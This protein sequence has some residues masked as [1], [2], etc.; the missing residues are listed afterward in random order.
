MPESPTPNQKPRRKRRWLRRMLW[1][2]LIFLGLLV[3]LH[4]PLV[5]Y[6]GRWVAIRIARG[7]NIELDLRIEG[8]V[9]SRLE[10]HDVKATKAGTGAAPIERLSLDRLVVEYSIPQLIRGD[11]NGL[12]SAEIGTLE[13]VITPLPDQKEPPPKPADPPAEVLRKLLAKPLPAPR[14][15]I[16][17]VDVRVKQV[18]GDLAVRNF[19]LHLTPGMPGTMGWDEI[20]LPGT[21]PLEAFRGTTQ[22]GPGDLR[23]LDVLDDATPA[24]A[25]AAK[26][27]TPGSIT[28][29]LN[30]L[31]FHL[32]AAVAP[33]ASGRAIKASVRLENL[34]VP[35]VAEKLGHELPLDAS[36]SKVAV[37]FAG[38]PEKPATWAATAEIAAASPGMRMIN[39]ARLSLRAALRE[40]LLHVENLDVSASGVRFHADGSLPVPPSIF[41][42][43]AKLP[44]VSGK[45]AFS[46]EAPDLAVLGEELKVPLAGG[47]KTTGTA[48]AEQGRLTLDVAMEARAVAAQGA[49]V[50]ET[51]LKLRATQA[52]EAMEDLRTLVAEAELT[53]HGIESAGVQI[54]TAR[55]TADLRELQ[56]R[57]RSLHVERGEST[58]DATATAK[59]T[60]KGA[61]AGSPEAQVSLLVP[62]LGDFQI[63]VNGAPLTGSASGEI[64]VA[65]GTPVEKS[66]GTFQL[67]AANL[68]LGDEAVGEMLVEGQIADGQV[69][70]KNISAQLAGQTTLAV[71][72]RFGIAA[73]HVYQA[74]VKL[75]APDLSA[76][77]PILAKL[78]Q[79]KPIA[80]KVAL[81]FEG[82]GDLAAPKG[83]VRLDA[84][85]VRYDTTKV[86]DAR[87]AANVTMDS[88]EVTEFLVVMD[89]LRAQAR[90]DWKERKVT[91]SNV[92]VQLDGN[93]VLSGSLNVP[94]DPWAPQP[95]PVNQPIQIDF[96]ARELDVARLLASLGQP[97]TAAGTVSATLKAG[98]TL[99]QPSLKLEAR[100]IKLRALPPPPDPKRST[101]K[102]PQPMGT[103]TA[104]N[105]V[106]PT[107]FET[108]VALEGSQLQVSGVIRQP[109]IQP[110]TFSANSTIDVKSLLEGK[111]LDW[112]A[113]PLKAS[114]DLPASSL[115]FLPRHVPAIARIDGTAAVAVRAGGTLG[116]P[117]LD[118]FTT[119]DV[120]LARMTAGSVPVITNFKS[121]LNFSG[122]RVSIGE[123]AGEAGGGRFTLSGSVGVA[124]FAEPVFDLALQSKD[125]L[126]LRDDSVLIRA[127]TDLALRGPLNAATATGTV[128]ITQSRFN[129]EI[130]ILPLQLPG[131]PKP[132]PK[133]AAQPTRIS[134]PKPPLRDWKFDIAVQ[135]RPD[136]PFLVRGNLAKGQAR[137][138]VKLAG[139]GLFPYLTGNATVEQFTA[140]LPLSTMTTRRGLVTFSQ[141]APFQPFLDLE[142]QSRIR[143]Y[144]IVAYINGPA[145]KPKLILESEPPLPQTEILSLLTTGSLTGEVGANNTALATR[146]A[147]LVVKSWYKKLFK[148]D[149][150]LTAEDTGGESI[151]D[152]FEV[153]VGAV[154]AKTGRSEITAQVRVTD[155]LF[156]I[157]DLEMGG[158]ISGRVKY[159]FRFR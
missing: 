63:A 100:G 95:L 124:N 107:D 55:L 108:T 48:T 59:L 20:E 144:T 22:F 75:D 92:E 74:K 38:D 153:D 69:L 80:G 126:V 88:A 89:K 37:T 147:V 125:V 156:F 29:T 14:V 110:L 82:A 6:G 109:L 31:G 123:F 53:S 104:P 65:L 9:W 105:A 41:E 99:A 33:A 151:M 15:S 116:K 128:F 117:T 118:G 68:R 129:K 140:V 36:V 66:T 119:L 2:F 35:A 152:R 50:R 73:P 47:L 72:G 18:D 137:V 90:V 51:V 130:E 84:K 34:D 159:L 135:T 3:A 142:A 43:G 145:D 12:R 54:E 64:K 98:G 106:P 40:Q 23:V 13:A 19:H 46:L 139:T 86:D 97:A 132:V 78:G 60:E 1:G 154:D 30:L 158:G 85:G 16:Q 115:A 143:Q 81:D 148:K 56:A 150:P 103:S 27:G 28:L 93:Q 134:F 61:L 32:E 131:K 4:R 121:R 101:I 112:K 70:A 5:H 113:L 67:R 146:A 76:F 96:A 24:F 26:P 120:K 10:L 8:N 91:V 44:P 83:L 87:L 58:V 127:E 122:D 155:R 141:D 77:G 111:A 138:D 57:V 7:Q 42:K 102:Q 71:E 21:P 79:K 52:L 45:F 17:R 114:V 39:D 94:F 11:L 49:K 62:S 133:V 157:G 149:F 25:F 136:D